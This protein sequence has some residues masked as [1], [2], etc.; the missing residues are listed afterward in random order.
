MKTPPQNRQDRFWWSLTAVF[1]L[2]V[3]LVALAIVIGGAA[4]A[5]HFLAKVW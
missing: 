1:L 4:V 3:T 5:I 2:A